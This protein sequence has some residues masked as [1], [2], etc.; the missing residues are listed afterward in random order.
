M[1]A[2]C[3]WRSMSS[4]FTAFAGTS[5]TLC[6]PGHLRG[7]ESP[8]RTRPCAGSWSAARCRARPMP[9]RW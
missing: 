6:S 2:N 4:S 5:T 1:W 8:A 9:A 3:R 7:S